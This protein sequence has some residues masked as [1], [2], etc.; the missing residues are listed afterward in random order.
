MNQEDGGASRQCGSHVPDLHRRALHSLIGSVARFCWA[1]CREMRLHNLLANSHEFGRVL[2]FEL[3]EEP[4]ALKVLL[5]FYSS[6]NQIVILVK[7]SF[8]KLPLKFPM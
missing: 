8:G 1:L 6:F 4:S 7:L 5:T 3:G 2:R